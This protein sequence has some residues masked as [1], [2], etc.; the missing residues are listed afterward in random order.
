MA[1]QAEDR[2]TTMADLAVALERKL[3]EKSVTADRCRYG[4]RKE[5]RAC[6]LLASTSAIQPTSRRIGNTALRS[7]RTRRVGWPVNRSD[8]TRAIANTG[9]RGRIRRW[10]PRANRSGHS[11]ISS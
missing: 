6:R 3:D 7:D 10:R 9:A 4:A 2:Y 1:K 8:G 11:A 5:T